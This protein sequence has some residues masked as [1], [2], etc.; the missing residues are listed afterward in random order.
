MCTTFVVQPTFISGFIFSP[1][2]FFL[3]SRFQNHSHFFTLPGIFFLFL[4]FSWNFSLP[5]LFLSS[6]FSLNV[7]F[8]HHFLSIIPSFE[9]QSSSV[10]HSQHL[11]FLSSNFRLPILFK[12]NSFPSFFKIL[13]TLLPEKNSPM[14]KLHAHVSLGL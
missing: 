5:F 14:K 10:R 13:K 8:S 1:T 3:A 2:S 7:Y 6:R 11:H 9:Y 12:R 4:N